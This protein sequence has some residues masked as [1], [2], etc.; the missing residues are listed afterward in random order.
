MRA[1]KSAP[2]GD[3]PSALGQK[4]KLESFNG[5]S[6]DAPA[7]EIKARFGPTFVERAIVNAQLEFPD[8][9]EFGFDQKYKKVFD[10]AQIET[11]CAFRRRLHRIIS[12]RG[13]LYYD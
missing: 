1:K 8:L 3:A 4:A 10:Y 13:S 11:A 2:G 5:H 12:P 9:G 7:L 6:Y